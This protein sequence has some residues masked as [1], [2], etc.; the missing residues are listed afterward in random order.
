M[1]QSVEGPD[2]HSILRAKH[3]REA[4]QALVLLA[5]MQMVGGVFLYFDLRRGDQLELLGSLLFQGL[6]AGLMLTLW[7]WS[8]RRPRGALVTAVAI[9]CVLLLAT[10]ILSPRTVLYGGVVAVVVTMVLFR[11]ARA[12]IADTKAA[13]G[14]PEQRHPLVDRG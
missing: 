7:A 3:M 12:A 5:I 10:I 4:R 13:R 2:R 8:R 14:A 6:L 9:W 1:S 11:G